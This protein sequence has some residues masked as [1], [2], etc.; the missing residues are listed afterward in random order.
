MRIAHPNTANGPR[1]NAII[2]RVCAEKGVLLQSATD[3]PDAVAKARAALGGEGVVLMSPGA[4][5]FGMYRDY[6]ARGKDFARIAGFDPE[7][8][9]EIPDQGIH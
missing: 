2:R 4:P 5:S 9:G 1:I 3:L 8:V 6:V 7:R